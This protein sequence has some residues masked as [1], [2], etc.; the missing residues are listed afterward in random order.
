MPFAASLAEYAARAIHQRQIVA[1][2][3]I[4]SLIAKSGIPRRVP[5]R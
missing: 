4:N 5:Y 3:E 1:E 2:R